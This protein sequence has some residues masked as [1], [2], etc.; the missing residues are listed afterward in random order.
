MT[1]CQTHGLLRGLPWAIL[2]GP[3]ASLF[4]SW[5]CLSPRTKESPPFR[6]HCKGLAGRQD[7]LWAQPATPLPGLRATCPSRAAL[8]SL[9]QTPTLPAG[10]AAPMGAAP[11]DGP[12]TCTHRSPRKHPTHPR[13]QPSPGPGPLGKLGGNRAGGLTPRPPLRCKWSLLPG[14]EGR[15]KGRARLTSLGERSGQRGAQVSD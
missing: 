14:L 2:L 1:L 5:A 12:G 7:S 11:S 8:V 10:H 13:P 9:T 3:S 4:R 6:G 15:K